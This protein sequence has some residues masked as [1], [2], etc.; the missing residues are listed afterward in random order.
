M[1]THQQIAALSS[2]E[3]AQLFDALAGHMFT[4]VRA[5]AEALGVTRATVYN[6]RDGDFPVMAVLA[7]Q[8]CVVVFRINA[9][10]DAAAQLSAIFAPV[11]PAQSAGTPSDGLSPSPASPQ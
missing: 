10:Q 7:M 3:R 2:A 9:M 4:S 5:V 1:L 8:S 11:A 6:W